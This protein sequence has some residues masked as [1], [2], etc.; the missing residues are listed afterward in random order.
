MT[1]ERD[2]ELRVLRAAQKDGG[3]VEEYFWVRGSTHGEGSSGSTF[4]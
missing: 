4:G 1:R 2:K 3:G